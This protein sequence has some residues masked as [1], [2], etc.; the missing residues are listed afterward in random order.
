MGGLIDM[1]VGVFWE[2]ST[3]FLKKVVLQF[4]PKYNQSYVNFNLKI[5]QNST[6]LKK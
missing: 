6:A 4:F 3:G 2:T 1:N 5:A